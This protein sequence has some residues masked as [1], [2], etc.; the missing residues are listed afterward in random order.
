MR[1]MDMRALRSLRRVVCGY[2][3]GQLRGYGL[4]YGTVVACR[5]VPDRRMVSQMT[6]DDDDVWSRADGYG[7]GTSAGCDAS[8]RCRLRYGRM[9]A[10]F[11]QTS[12][13]FASDNG[14]RLSTR[15][16][17]ADGWFG[18]IVGFVYGWP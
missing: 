2:A 15:I 11:T 16:V 13:R 1:L 9:Y 4:R 18:W 3:A 14:C 5:P 8:V 17:C 12:V 10:Q 6:D 7:Y